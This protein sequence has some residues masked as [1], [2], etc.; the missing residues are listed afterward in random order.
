LETLDPTAWTVSVRGSDLNPRSVAHAAAGR[1]SPQEIRGLAPALA[2]KYFPP[3]ETDGQKVHVATHA[4][5][6][7]IE[8]E[9]RNLARPQK[10]PWSPQDV[11]VCQNVLIYLEPSLRAVLV[12]WLCDQLVPGGYLVVTPAE[13]V[14][15][16]PNNTRLE[17]LPDVLVFRRNL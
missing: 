15:L 1:Y 2:T 7:C 3:R 10:L 11:I 6:A 9:V 8:F 14:G 5:R 16:T 13:V 12:Q 4:L 17:R